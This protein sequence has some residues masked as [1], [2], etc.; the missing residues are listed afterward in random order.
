M[1]T[2]PLFQMPG[3]SPHL[4][5]RNIAKVWWSKGCAW[6]NE[7]GSPSL[8]P[9]RAGLFTRLA[10]RAL[11]RPE[12]API[13]R[14]ADW[15]LGDSWK[16]PAVRVLFTGNDYSEVFEYA[17]DAEAEA[18]HDKLLAALQ[19]AK[20]RRSGQAASASDRDRKVLIAS[21]DTFGFVLQRM[22]N[23][24]RSEPE[25]PER[26]RFLER[27]NAILEAMDR[28]DTALGGER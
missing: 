27:H 12:P 13:M 26:A 15:M 25:T 5:L 14:E 8:V 10:S 4:H 17:S 23:D 9:Q 22:T 16:S 20:T 24:D 7:A 1:T 18:A 28:I 19:A 11:G 21:R 2:S 3:Y 6:D